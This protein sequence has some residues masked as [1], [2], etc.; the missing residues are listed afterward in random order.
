MADQLVELADQGDEHCRRDRC[1]VVYGVVR[2]SMWKIR[3]AI[4]A[5]HEQDVACCRP[6]PAD[7]RTGERNGKEGSKCCNARRHA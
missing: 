3:T 5:C 6:E 7:T 2:D 4:H 1:L